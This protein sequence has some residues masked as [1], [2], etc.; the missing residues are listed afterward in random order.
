VCVGGTLGAVLHVTSK[1]CTGT[2]EIAARVC[3]DTVLGGSYGKHC[4]QQLLT[5][6]PHCS[7]Q[8][9]AQAVMTAYQAD[10]QVCQC[11]VSLSE[12]LRTK[13]QHKTNMI[14]MLLWPE[15]P[16]LRAIMVAGGRL[17]NMNIS[18]CTTESA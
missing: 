12:I 18:A 16:C 3:K 13:V 17:V 14:C 15:L 7:N 5:A 9:T 4:G 6:Q 11:Q 8:L 2:D 10:P 1:P